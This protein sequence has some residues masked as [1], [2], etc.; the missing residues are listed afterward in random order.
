MFK[1][2]AYFKDSAFLFNNSDSN[3][4]HIQRKKLTQHGTADLEGVLH[5]DLAQQTKAIPNGVPFTVKL[6]QND[7]S[8]RLFAT[9]GVKYQLEVIEAVL[10]VCHVTLKPSVLLAHNEQLKRGPA[11]YPFWRSDIKTHGISR[12]SYGF[13][14]DDVFNGVTPNKLVVALVPSVAFTGDYSKNPFFFHHFNLNVI[15]FC[16]DGEAMPTEA[17]EPKFQVNPDTPTQYLPTG[18]VQSFLSLFKHR[19]PQAESN[20]ISRWV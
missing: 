3:P 10:R 20:W 12:G 7:D 19:Y 13:T 4:G 15:E 14:I 6:H 17:F 16:V 8:F 11:V 2:E 18:Y 1:S 5:I 9:D